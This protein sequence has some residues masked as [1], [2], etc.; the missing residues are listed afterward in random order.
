MEL[1]IHSKTLDQQRCTLT[2]E[3]KLT[4]LNA[5]ELKSNIEQLIQ[6]GTTQFIV[7]LSKISFIDSSGLSALI[8]GLKAARE[9]KGYLKLAGLNEQVGTIFRLT[10]LDRVFEMYRNVEA[11]IKS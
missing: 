1:T 10:K 8:G 5:P 9:A 6:K 7:D 3:G 4:A 11:A 2:L